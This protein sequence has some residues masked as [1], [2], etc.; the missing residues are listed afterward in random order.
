MGAVY[1][2]RDTQLDRFVALK[3]LRAE[4]EAESEYAQQLQRE[5]RVTASVNHPNV[6]Q[7]Y[8]S[9][10]DHDK[11]YL[12]MELV[13]QGSLEDLMVQHERV[14]EE[15]VLETGIQVAKGLSAAY[16]KDLIH[17]DVKPA[18]I[19]YADE[20]TAKIGDFGLAGV[21]AGKEAQSMGAIWG[22]PYY[23][24]PERLNNEAEDFRSDI[25]SL[26][27]T[28]YHAIAGKPPFEGETNSAAELR[29]LKSN[30]VDLRIAAPDVSK[31]TAQIINKMI[32]PDAAA[33][34][35]SYDEVVAQLEKAYRT[36]RGLKDGSLRRRAIIRSAIAAA[37]VIAMAAAYFYYS[38]TRTLQ[39]I[40]TKAAESATNIPL[41]ELER[42][43]AEARRQLVIG[44][45]NVARMAF[46]RLAVDAKNARPLRD[47][48]RLQQGLA[49]MVGRDNGEARQAFQEVT[50]AGEQGLKE[51]AD[52]A[53][54]LLATARK[55][56]ASGAISAADAASLK[57]DSAETFALLLF[58]LKNVAEAAAKEAIPMLEQFVAAQPGGQFAWIADYKP[59][60]QKYLDDARLYAALKEKS[61]DQDFAKSPEYLKELR[62]VRNKLKMKS[63][64]S[65]ELMAEEKSIG[66][67][68]ATQQKTQNSNREEA[69]RKIVDVEQPR[70]NAAIAAYKQNLAIYDFASAAA[71]MKSV[72]ISDAELKVEQEM[73]QNK[74]QWL[75]DWKA[76]LID[77]LNRTRFAGAIKD[78]T[79]LD[80]IGIDGATPQK[81]AAKNPY[82]I[83]Q[84][85][86]AKFSPKTLFTVSA[87]F[88]K[89]NMSDAADRQW[90]CA[91]FAHE[92]GQ[93]EAALSLA[94]TAADAKPEYAQ[95]MSIFDSPAKTSR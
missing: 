59:L 49:A 22:T 61:S 18:N 93:G 27:A 13:D 90:V 42:Q 32:A 16:A 20:H 87:A 92:T 56:S 50:K 85:D 65:A 24:A 34:Y 69:R 38:K 64:L 82:G 17:R 29:D 78:V 9:G 86:W 12:V 89:P 35:G 74:A 66:P 36:L 77:D 51:D 95:N 91:V 88:I 72:Q 33:R 31:K 26:G 14:S 43:V 75:A 83:V 47:F 48:I 30:P 11:F 44:H 6:I 1:K 19:L 15:Q 94:Q 52:L 70:L 84:L 7:V 41:P 46:A 76:K 54:F 40:A 28:L 23:V 57:R 67:R 8:S 55:L 37:V 73:F 58:G 63:S 25:Y 21:A 39:T 5:A 60:A 53:R 62:S 3:L 4:L 45:H 79:G 81:L 80:Y 68:I 10:T 2:A 71:V